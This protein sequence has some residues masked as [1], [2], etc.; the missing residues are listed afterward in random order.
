MSGADILPRDAKARIDRFNS[1]RE[2]ER[3]A[4][5]YREMC[6]SP[7]SF[8]RGSAHLFWEDLATR[9]GVLPNSPLVWA[10]GDLHL[11]NFGSFQSNNGLAYFDLNDF[12][13]A[14][15]A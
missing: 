10:C 15:L 7:F 8:F 13:E 4:L 1:G 14:A 3:L 12:D 2:P 6:K 11:E 5:K 9:K